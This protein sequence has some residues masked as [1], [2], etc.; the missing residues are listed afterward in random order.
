[1]N[2]L[3]KVTVSNPD[4]HTTI[5]PDVLDEG[6]TKYHNV[7]ICKHDFGLWTAHDLISVLA[8]LKTYVKVYCLEEKTDE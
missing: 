1:M 6:T 3:V 2:Q 4:T 7:T 5:S 8:V